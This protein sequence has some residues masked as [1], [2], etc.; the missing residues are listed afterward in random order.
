MKIEIVSSGDGSHTLFLPDMNETYHSMH[1]AVAESQYVFI[2]KG[3]EEAAKGLNEIRILEIGFGTGLNTLLSLKWAEEQKKKVYYTT[4]EPFPLSDEVV[5][6]LNYGSMVASPYAENYQVLHK[7]SWEESVV[8]TEFFT[9]TKHK[10][11]LEEAVLQDSFD[12]IYF[13]AF[14]PN[15]QA[16]VWDLSNIGKCY[17]L[18]NKGSILVSYCAQGQFKRNL[19]AAGF[20]LEVL[21]GPPGKKEMTRAVKLRD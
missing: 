6:K 20:E 12:L 2:D 3:L 7:S 19:K 1:G 11:K 8:L 4:L 15:K 21:S 18:L 13:D 17:S 10:T 9:L 16:E 5:D 14:A